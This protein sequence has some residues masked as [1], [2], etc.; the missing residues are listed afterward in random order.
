MLNEKSLEDIGRERTNISQ[1]WPFWNRNEEKLATLS[2][3][4]YDLTFHW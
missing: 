2:R 1:G 4:A 3:L